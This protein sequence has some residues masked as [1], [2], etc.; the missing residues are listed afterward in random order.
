L[1]V[2]LVQA[3]AEDRHQTTDTRLKTTGIRRKSRLRIAE[4]VK[5]KSKMQKVKLQFKIQN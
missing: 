4:K 3:C 5:V 2:T 1:V